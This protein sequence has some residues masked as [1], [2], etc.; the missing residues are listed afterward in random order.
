MEARN[1]MTKPVWDRALPN[2]IAFI[3]Y[4]EHCARYAQQLTGH[5]TA[6]GHGLKHRLFSA[7]EFQQKYGVPR[8]I[9]QRPGNLAADATAV[10]IFNSNK[11]WEAY[12]LQQSMDGVLEAAVES[13]Y[14]EE[15]RAVLEI[16]FSLDHL[17]LHEQGINLRAA[18][19]TTETDIVWLTKEISKP[20]A[21]QEKIETC[22]AKQIQYLGC[23]TAIGQAPSRWSRFA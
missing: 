21:R 1:H 5:A 10:D 2:S 23:L 17:M 12:N 14:P 11:L 19:P 18:L 8:A 13:G 16:N 22:T 7:A 6:D 9:L 4:R 3:K 15:I 20:W